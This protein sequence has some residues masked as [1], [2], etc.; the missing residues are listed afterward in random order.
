MGILLG[1][2]GSIKLGTSL[3]RNVTRGKLTPKVIF[4]TGVPSD[5]KRT[6]ISGGEEKGPGAVCG[7][8][9]MLLQ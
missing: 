9:K 6:S 4:A 7:E 2:E 3:H 5:S 1:A 8:A